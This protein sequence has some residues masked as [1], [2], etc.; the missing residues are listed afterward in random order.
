MTSRPC[1]FSRFV[2]MTNSNNFNAHTK[3]LFQQAHKWR[4]TQQA[5][6]NKAKSMRFT[7]MPLYNTN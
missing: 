3:G 5:T 6:K 2:C 1:L 7:F 4:A